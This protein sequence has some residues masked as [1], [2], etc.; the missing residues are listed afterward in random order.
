MV[1]KVSENILKATTYWQNKN[2]HLK[3]KDKDES[4][5][6]IQERNPLNLADICQ[7]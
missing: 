2:E 1:E 4:W 5:K 3:S 6:I 7:V